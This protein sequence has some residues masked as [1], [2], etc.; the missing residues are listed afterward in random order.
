[1]EYIACSKG[2]SINNHSETSHFLRPYLII[3]LI[4]FTNYKWYITNGGMNILGLAYFKVYQVEK[5]PKVHKI[6]RNHLV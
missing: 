2:K 3:L 5:K 1:M 4:L 6:Y